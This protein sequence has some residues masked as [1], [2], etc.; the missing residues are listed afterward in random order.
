VPQHHAFHRDFNRLTP[1]T[2]RAINDL[3]VQAAVDLGFEDGSKLRHHGGGDRH[4]SSNRQHAV[5]GVIRVITRLI[6]YL[7]EAMNFQRFKVF[8]ITSARPGIGCKKSNALTH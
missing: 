2:L 3:V 7:A 1:D 8:S 5:V 4:S 6:G